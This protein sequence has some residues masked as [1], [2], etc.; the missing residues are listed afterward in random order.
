MGL[1]LKYCNISLRLFCVCGMSDE[2]LIIKLTLNIPIYQAK[3]ES[4]ILSCKAAKDDSAG[5]KGLWDAVSDRMFSLADRQKELGLG[6]K[7]C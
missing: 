6:E 3:F 2:S 1:K 4:L 7:V 5:I